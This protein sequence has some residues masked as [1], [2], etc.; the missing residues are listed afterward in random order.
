MQ[1]TYSVVSI[2]A[3]LKKYS[4]LVKIICTWILLERLILENSHMYPYHQE[5]FK[6]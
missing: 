3:T 6:V 4:L 1:Y 2:R 5:L